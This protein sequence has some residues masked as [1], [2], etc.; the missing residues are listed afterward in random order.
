MWKGVLR[1]GEEQVPFKLFAAAVDRGVHFRLLHAED[2]TPVRQRMVHPGT[3]ETVPQEEV[4]RGVEVAPGEFVVL[5]EAELAAVEPQASRDVRVERFVASGSIGAER[6]DRPYYLLPDGAA[7]PYR[8]L[9]KALAD[10]DSEGIATWVM[11]KR[12]YAGSLRPSGDVLALVTLRYA[13]QAAPLERLAF[14]T[15]EITNQERALARQL[16]ATLAGEFEPEAFRD[17]YRERVEELVAQKREGRTI[18]LERYRSKPVAD[19]ALLEALEA[20]VRQAG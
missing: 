9:L 11:R 16:V 1:I 6:Y 15:G 17:E 7:A 18:R 3:G 13:A 14:E 12:F 19:E 5:D 8:A 2:L 20:S 10:T 4:R